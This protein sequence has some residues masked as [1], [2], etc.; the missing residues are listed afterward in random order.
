MDRIQQYQ[1]EIGPHPAASWDP[2]ALAQLE[3]LLRSHPRAGALRTLQTSC[4]AWAI[5]FAE[6]AKEHTIY[7]VD[8]T[9][10]PKSAVNFVQQ[11]PQFRERSVRW[12]NGPAERM[13]LEQVPQTP[14]DIVLLDGPHAYPLPQVEYFALYPFLRP[15]SML[16]VDDVHIPTVNQLFQFLR[17]DESF[18]CRWRSKAA[19]F[20]ERTDS[21]TSDMELNGWWLQRYNAQNF[22]VWQMEYAAAGLRLPIKLD[23]DSGL[24]SSAPVLTRG[25]SL[26]DNQPLSEG[27]HSTIELPL[28]AEAPSQVCVELEVEPVCLAE[29]ERTGVSLHVN[30]VYA[31]D[32]DFES[33]G[34]QLLGATVST[35]R[36]E[37]VL[38]LEFRNRGLK[39]AN[40]LRDWIKPRGFDPRLPN[41]WL[42]SVAV[43]DNMAVRPTTPTTLQRGDGCITS[44]DYEGKQFRFFVDQEDDSVQ[45]FHTL[46]RF[47]E[48]DELE[49]IREYVPRGAR[50]LDVGAHIGNH[51][52]YFA[53]VLEAARVVA[54]EPNPRAQTLLRLNRALNDADA[55]DLCYLGDALG[56]AATA[57]SLVL[58]DLYNSGGASVQL[59]AGPV[60]V[61]RGDELLAAEHFDFI[62]I[63][64]EGMELDVLTGLE[65]LIAAS[66][67]L[68]F[69]EVRDENT[70]PFRSVLEAWSYRIDWRGQMYPGITNFLISPCERH[71]N[72]R[73]S[74]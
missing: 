53:A 51:S 12:V 47:Y 39:L 74:D 37:H 13:V 70:M 35:P 59:G 17:Q 68:I 2:K 31:G 65:R 4:S 28:E 14:L 72:G 10:S 9:L 49:L 71:P 23:F 40:E 6:Y 60:Q 66:R 64:V 73:V 46:G 38:K 15:G 58:S 48:L 20:F 41:F 1:R 62:K 8:D 36:R 54:I 16:I 34:R 22:P 27:L 50:I 7:C 24:R 32:W 57:G 52:V 25:F 3:Q 18:I 30:G 44:F 56:S 26:K 45:V 61:R 42:H 63:D 69:I 33:P 29:R 55:I 5:V 67:P 19:A 11:F 43:S 21:P